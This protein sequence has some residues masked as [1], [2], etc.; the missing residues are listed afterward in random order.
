MRPKVAVI[1]GYFD[2]FSGYHEVSLAQA[3]SKLGE[4]TVFTGDIV[5]PIFSDAHLEGI[6]MGRRYKKLQEVHHGITVKRFAALEVRSMVFARGLR[7]AV[8]QGGF[9]LVVQFS[10]GFVFPAAAS[11]PRLSCPRVVLYGDNSA[12]YANLSPLLARVKYLIFAATKG[13]LYAVVNSRAQVIYGYTPETLDRL[14]PFAAGRKMEVAPLTY[15][16]K[17]FY[18]DPQE[19]EEMRLE[20]GV[21]YDERLIIGAGKINQQKRFDLLV[22]AFEELAAEDEKL[23][24]AILGLS[25]DRASSDLRE[26]VSNS[27]VRDRISILPFGDQETLRKFF[28]AADVGV[29]PRMPAITIQQAMGTG[30]RVVLPKSLTVSHL[31]STDVSG[32]YFEDLGEDFDQMRDAIREITLS[33]AHRE[34]VARRNEWMSS[35]VVASTLLIRHTGFTE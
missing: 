4:V 12:M 8:Q 14:R 27:V 23:R 10:P 35:Q 32:R 19:R 34:D 13:V 9:D 7:K 20:L 24:L 1:C 11:F 26:L 31:I 29:W 18:F 3:F 30:L 28:N 6:G 16:G 2:L 15:D 22:R 21:G 25:V 5:S 17:S 33:D